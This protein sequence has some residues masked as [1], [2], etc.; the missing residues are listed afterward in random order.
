MKTDYNINNSKTK[1]NNEDQ[2]IYNK[3]RKE[4]AK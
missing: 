3:K 1:K 4:I 2:T